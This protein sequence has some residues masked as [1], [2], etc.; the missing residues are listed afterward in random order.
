MENNIRNQ[1]KLE[2]ILEFKVQYLKK[3]KITGESSTTNLNSHRKESG[4]GG[5]CL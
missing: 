3:K 4:P 1:M 2:E 5:S